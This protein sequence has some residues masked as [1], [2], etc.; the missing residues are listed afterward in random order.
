MLGGCLRGCL[1]G[2]LGGVGGVL[3]WLGV[4][5]GVRARKSWGK[6]IALLAGARDAVNGKKNHPTGGFL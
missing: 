4:E 6:P 1:G 5:L 2:C 3:G